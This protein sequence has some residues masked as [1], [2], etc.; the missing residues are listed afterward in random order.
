MKKIRSKALK[1]AWV[2]I[3][4]MFIMALSL[5]SAWG[6]RSSFKSLLFDLDRLL[7]ILDRKS[8]V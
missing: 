4:D 5:V 3:F 1:G 6:I 2:I 8:V 7:F